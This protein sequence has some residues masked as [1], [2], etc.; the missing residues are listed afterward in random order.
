VKANKRVRDLKRRPKRSVRRVVDYGGIL[1]STTGLWGVYERDR[2]L[3]YGDGAV[4][5]CTKRS[6]A[7]LATRYPETDCR[8]VRVTVEPDE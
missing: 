1:K 8:R 2:I 3:R 4:W 5:V 6:E 7:E